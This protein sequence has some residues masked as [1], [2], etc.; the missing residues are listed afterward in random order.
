MPNLARLSDKLLSTRERLVAHQEQAQCASCHRK[1]DP[2]GFGL[3]NFDAVGLW[4]TENSYKV[5]RKDGEKEVKQK[6]WRIDSSGRIHNGP[7]FADYFE[8]RDHIATHHDAFAK[9]FASAVIEYGMG[10]SIG[11]SDQTL[12]DEIAQRA[13]KDDYAIRSFFHAI[14]QHQAFQKK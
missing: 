2:I 6:Q 5:P 7:A 8:L 9:S 3:E 14:V 4:R 10:R 13:G 1:I 12:I 11:F